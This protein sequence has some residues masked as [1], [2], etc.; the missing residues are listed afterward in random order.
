M[1][2]FNYRYHDVV[3][4]LVVVSRYRT[5]DE[6]DWPFI[7]STCG[8]SAE[9]SARNSP[10]HHQR[11]G[12]VHREWPIAEQ[13]LFEHAPYYSSRRPVDS[14]PLRGLPASLLAVLLGFSSLAERSL[15]HSMD[16]LARKV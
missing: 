16:I 4:A 10:L 3:N 13:L 6:E 15:L 8:S 12:H 2:S 5:A 1:C 14:E 11:V 9:T 7:H